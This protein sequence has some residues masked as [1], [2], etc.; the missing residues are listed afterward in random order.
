[1]SRPR[2]SFLLTAAHLGA[3]DHDQPNQYQSAHRSELA[4]RRSLESFVLKPLLKRVGAS[5][6][7]LGSTWARPSSVPLASDVDHDEDP[8]VAYCSYG[9]RAMVP[10]CGDDEGFANVAWGFRPGL[11]GRGRGPE[12]IRAVAEH[13]RAHSQPSPLV[14]KR[15]RGLLPRRLSKVL[16]AA[17][18]P[19]RPGY[20]GPRREK[21]VV[22]GHTFECRVC[23]RM[24]E[25]IQRVLRGSRKLEGSGVPTATPTLSGRPRGVPRL[26][27]LSPSPIPD[28]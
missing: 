7:E 18:A 27:Q 16:G 26:S 8:L 10:M 22:V 5:T 3:S 15:D 6:S 13:G 24:M 25:D 9:R 23:V 19:V 12:L 14:D 2:D 17:M 21:R 20:L 28:R 11:E 1:V 4:L